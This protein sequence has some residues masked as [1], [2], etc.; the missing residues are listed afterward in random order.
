ME[1]ENEQGK[2]KGR[3][4]KAETWQKINQRRTGSLEKKISELKD[5]KKARRSWKEK[6]GP[7]NSS[8]KEGKLQQ[9]PTKT[10]AVDSLKDWTC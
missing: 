3:V 1:K 10:Y 5:Q 4:F 6:G 9:F 8:K 2:V 7:A